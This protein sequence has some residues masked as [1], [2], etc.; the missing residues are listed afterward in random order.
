[1]SVD[2][3]VGMMIMPMFTLRK[4]INL[5]IKLSSTDHAF[6]VQQI[7]QGM[8]EVFVIGVGLVRTDR[9]FLQLPNERCLKLGPR[10]HT[11]LG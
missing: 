6:T 1:M 10:K 11:A 4:V 7:S 2:V 5:M 9:H 8:Q 3:N